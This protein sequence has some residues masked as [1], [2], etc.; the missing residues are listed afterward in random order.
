MDITQA[1]G[2]LAGFIAYNPVT[3]LFIVGTGLYLSLKL[4]W[5]QLRKLPSAWRL[6]WTKGSATGI[7]RFSTLSTALSATV[8]TG[9]IAGVATAIILGG[10]GALFWMWVTAVVG[11]ATKFAESTL[12]VRFRRLNGDIAGG[13][14]YTLYD[15]LGFKKLAILFAVFGVFTSLALGNLVQANSVVDGLAFI[16]PEAKQ[17]GVWI[18]ISLAIPTA[19]VILGGIVRIARLASVIVPLM[20]LLYLIAVILVIVDHIDVLPQAIG[21]VFNEALNIQAV[22]AAAIGEAIRWGVIRGLFSNEAGLGSSAII[23]AAA[24]TEKPAE[25]G[26]IAMLEPLIDTLIICTLT[27][28]TLIVTGAAAAADAGQS[29][30][31]TAAAFATTLGPAGAYVVSFSLILFAF[32]TLLAWS[33]LGDRCCIFLLGPHSVT[34]YR[35]VFIGFV[36]LGA[37][38]PLR[39]VWSIADITAVLMAIPNL[40]AIW[41]LLPTLIK[42]SKQLREPS[43]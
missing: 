24:N 23:H 8:G 10:P 11:M 27:G 38:V 18:G 3:L 41:W 9:N 7:S 25:E 29:A 39:L 32:S 40:I 33:Y 28:L 31:V 12:A 36:V 35:W 30:S 21:S 20:S 43:Y 2:N 4:R 14:M 42:L 13:P 15:G 1:I 26:L 37:S 34:A 22:G 5:I 17:N 19:L 16:W 6:L